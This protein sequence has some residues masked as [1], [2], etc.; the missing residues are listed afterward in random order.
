MGRGE[1]AELKERKRKGKGDGGGDNVMPRK[2]K[3]KK[4]AAKRFKITKTGRVK[5]AKSFSGHLLSWKSRK[6]KRRLK[7]SNYC[8]SSEAKIIKK[9]LPYA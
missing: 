9:L 6:R 3:T 7:K 2:M 1:I 8:F 5:K 4:G